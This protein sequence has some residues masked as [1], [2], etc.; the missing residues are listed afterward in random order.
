MGETVCFLVF[1]LKC[2]YGKGT[3]IIRRLDETKLAK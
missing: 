3:E 2:P 1:A